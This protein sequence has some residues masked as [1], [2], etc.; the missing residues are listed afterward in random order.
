MRTSVKILLGCLALPFVVVAV[1]LVLMLAFR[2]APLPESEVAT[3]DLQQPLPSVTAEQLAAEGLTV[4]AAAPAGSAMPVSLVLEEGNFTVMPGPPGSG[5]RIEGNFD[6]AMY[7]LKQE[8]TQDETGAPSY[9]LSFKPRYSM[10]RRLL[11]QGA[12]EIDE[13]TNTLTI[14]LPEGVPM[15]LEAKIRIGQSEM[16]LGGLALRSAN[17]SLEMGEHRVHV[18]R[19]NPIEMSS[20]EMNSGMGEVRLDGIGNLRSGSITLFGKM[21]EVRLDMGRDLLCDTTLLTRMRMGEMRV[22][23]PGNAR[24]SGSATAFLGEVNGSPNFGSEDGSDDTHTI[25]VR[26]SITLGQLDYQR[27]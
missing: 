4:N 7:E 6:E 11:S 10:L 18:D 19:P 17:F 8:M 25:E 3:A 15:A 22:H 5:I 2:A 27:Y 12:V 13:N 16:Q 23:L 24:S 20:L 14:Y 21:G 9:A 1:L 26:G